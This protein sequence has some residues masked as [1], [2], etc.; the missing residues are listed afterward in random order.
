MKQPPTKVPTIVHLFC[1]VRRGLAEARLFVARFASARASAWLLSTL[2][3]QIDV[4]LGGAT[5]LALLVKH[6]L[7]CF[8]CV[9]SCQGSPSLI[10]RFA[11]FDENLR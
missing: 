4:F 6:G 2:L 8:M 10:T 7:A 1:A 3:E 11:A 5:C 9:S